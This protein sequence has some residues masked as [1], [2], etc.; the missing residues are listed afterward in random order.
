MLQEGVSQNQR[1]SCFRLA[2]NL[3]KIGIPYDMAESILKL[4]AQKNKPNPKKRII[5][6]KE[7]IEQTSYAYNKHYR[8]YGCESPAVRSFCHPECRVISRLSVSSV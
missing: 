6:D 5:T 4:W 8:G 7:I 1:V 2:I 3:K